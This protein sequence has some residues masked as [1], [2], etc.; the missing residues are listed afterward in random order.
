M[1]ELR[2]PVRVENFAVRRESGGAGRH[3]GGDGVIRRLKF[4]EPMTVSLLANR[5]RV[6]PFGLSGGA[7]AKP[8]AGRVIRANGAI[9]PLAATAR[10]EVQS[11]DAVEIETPGGGGFGRV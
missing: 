4:L 3:K 5:R 9:E 7:D 11:G 6:A 2:F 1:L 10:A 8:G